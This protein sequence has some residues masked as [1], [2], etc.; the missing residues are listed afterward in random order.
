VGQVGQVGQVGT[1][2]LVSI[3]ASRGG[4][5]KLPRHQAVIT[6]EGVDGDRQRDLRYHGGPERAVCLYSFDRIRELQQEGHAVSVGLMGEN[7]TVMGLDWRLL[8]P[9]T[10]VQIGDVLLLLT[11]FAVPCK[12][13]S[14]YFDAGKI[15]RV[16]QKVHPGWSRV[17]ARVQRPGTV[18]I[19]DS[20]SIVEGGRLPPPVD[21]STRLT[22]KRSGTLRVSAPLER[23]FPYFTPD[24]E[25]L[26]VPGFDPQ[27]LHPLTGEQG[28]GAIFTTNHGGED[29]L[30]MVLRFSPAEGAAE[31]ARVTPGSRG[32][33]VA[34]ALHRVDEATTEATITY[35]LTSTSDSGDGKLAALTQE[36]Y[37]AMLADWE[38]R[39]ERVLN[40]DSFG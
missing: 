31:Y 35:E 11:N 39:I 38:Q 27:Y 21:A 29:T 33:T 23:A 32:G 13:L 17:Y 4:V 6:A 25:R 19:G 3:N 2:T 18:R 26:W 14:S 36:A 34:V 15:F 28:I 1:G 5:P 16:S 7:L 20:V 30:W 9:G 8:T 22:V 37:A 12:N 10:R 24:G 40:D